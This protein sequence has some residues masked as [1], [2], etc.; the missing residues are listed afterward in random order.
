MYNVYLYVAVLQSYHYA[1]GWL[2]KKNLIGGG[3]R[4]LFFELVRHE[5]IFYTGDDSPIRT[6]A[7]LSYVV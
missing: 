5:I 1:S 6:I 2:K 3:W 4:M 7:A